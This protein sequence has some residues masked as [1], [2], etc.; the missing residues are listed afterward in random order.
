MWE[1]DGGGGTSIL[2][3]GGGGGEG[4]PQETFPHVAKQIIQATLS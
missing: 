4:L 3:R 1:V 2:G